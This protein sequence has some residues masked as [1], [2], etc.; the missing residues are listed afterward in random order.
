[1]EIYP[2]EQEAVAGQM[3]IEFVDPTVDSDWDREVLSHPAANAFHSSAW[4]RVL[5]AT[6]G[7][8]RLYLRCSR[9]DRLLA[10]V[11]FM[12]VQ[13]LVRARRGISLPFSDFCDS[14]LFDPHCE[15]ELFRRIGQIAADRSW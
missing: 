1:T 14:L 7:H 15:E 2:M 11:P 10:L 9:A 13:S 12:E 6:Y 5:A 3:S 4:A 8:Q